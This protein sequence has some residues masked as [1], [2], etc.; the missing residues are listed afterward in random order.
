MTLPFQHISKPRVS[1]PGSGLLACVLALGFVMGSFVLAA[2][3]NPM[4]GF[5]IGG[6]VLQKD[7]PN[8]STNLRFGTFAPW[9]TDL[10]VN[11]WNLPF[12]AGPVYF[13][14]HGQADNGGANWLEHKT[15]G[16]LS[17]WDSA[18][19][20]FWDGANVRIYR[21]VDG[22]MTQI[23]TAVVSSSSMG[24]DPA[25]GLY[26]EDQKLWF[27]EA[28][29][30]VRTGDYYVLRMKRTEHPPQYR[31]ALSA[32]SASPLLNGHCQIN[33]NGTWSF[34][35]S[36]KAPEGGS[37][38]SLK[39]LAQQASPSV[40]CGPWHWYV[41]HGD[42]DNGKARFRAGKQ[43][44]AQVWL[45]QE[46]MS[47]PRV[48]LQF[49]TIMTRTVTVDEVWRKY[50][51]DLPVHS[52]ESPYQ[53]AAQG[54]TTRML[55]GAVS[56][57]TFWIDN[58]VVYQADEPP[59][60][61]LREEVEILKKFRPHTLRLWG[62]LDAMSLE[63]WLN[64]G[65]AMPTAMKRFARTAFPKA[66]WT[67]IPTR[68]LSE[69]PLE[70]NLLPLDY[71]EVSGPRG[72]N[73]SGHAAHADTENWKCQGFDRNLW[74]VS[75][76]Y[77]R[78]FLNARIPEDSGF[79]VRYR[80]SISPAFHASD[81][82]RDLSVAV[83]RPW[84]A[85]VFCN[86][87][88][89]DSTE[90]PVWFDEEMRLL[91]LGGFLQAGGNT[92]ELRYARFHVRA[93]IMPVILRGRFR[94]DPDDPGFRLEPATPWVPGSDRREHGWG[95]YPG[96]SGQSHTFELALRSRMRIRLPDFQGS[97]IGVSIDGS[98]PV[99][100]HHPGLE[101]E[102]PSPLEPGVHRLDMILCGHLLNLLGPHFHNGLPGA[103]S[104]E[105]SPREPV[106]GS[107]YRLLPVCHGG[108]PIVSSSAGLPGH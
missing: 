59:F 70:P 105:N 94:A 97:A 25:T 52:P 49:G 88:P 13:Q 102:W 77:R 3:G 21:I 54:A 22:V 84:L 38:A 9:N 91:P 43:Y 12:A 65:F 66:S 18:R 83:E 60:G 10:F 33:G 30:P 76:Q 34:D 41:I 106:P 14:N 67:T 78:T 26:L 51:F 81:A 23:R 39:I 32:P 100:D 17:E 40:P 44:K 98:A 95:F 74:K 73:F 72:L 8:F 36:T 92:L 58:F 6:E 89:V 86:D 101:I 61:V 16:G 64:E 2:R 28:G 42:S 20:G 1:T 107:A 45:K 68:C 31:P 7:A 103:W 99:W 71:C 15:G 57:G 79:T 35:E 96:R 90:C 27:E 85:S 29:E 56:P 104:W 48:T 80:F 53:T 93:E 11:A 47:D 69:E 50:E 19:S 55:I 75:I 63:Y 37:Q 87:Q 62:G 108:G 24:K 46:G 5:R 4:D 82:A